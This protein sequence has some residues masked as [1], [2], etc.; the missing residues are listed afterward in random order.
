MD[1]TIAV[2]TKDTQVMDLI[3]M[4]RTRAHRRSTS[5][6]QMQPVSIIR[7]PLSALVKQDLPEMVLTVKMST[8]AC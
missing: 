5:V 7:D 8:S 6:T 3:V 2:A 4:I 1:L